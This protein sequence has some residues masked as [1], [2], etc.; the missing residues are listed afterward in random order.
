MGITFFFIHTT[1]LGTGMENA[2]PAYALV[3]SAAV[4]VLIFLTGDGG[5]AAFIRRLQDIQDIKDT[6]GDR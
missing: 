1:V 5:Q 6:K 2:S 3:L 4:T